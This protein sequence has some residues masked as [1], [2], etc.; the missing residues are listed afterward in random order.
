LRPKIADLYIH[1]RKCFARYFT[2]IF[3]LVNKSGS[4]HVAHLRVFLE[5]A[6]TIRYEDLLLTSLSRSSSGKPAAQKKLFLC[7][8][9]RSTLLEILSREKRKKI[10]ARG[11]W[12]REM[13]QVECEFCEHLSTQLDFTTPS[14][15]PII[16]K[17]P[18][19]I[20]IIFVLI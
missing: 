14:D 12:V 20:I 3:L 4:N 15:K 13:H 8:H 18:L 5:C 2:M 7:F 19:Q 1:R 9:T 17:P 11:D 10:M 6:F 16:D